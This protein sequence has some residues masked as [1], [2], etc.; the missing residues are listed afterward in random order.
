VPRSLRVR[1]DARRGEGARGRHL[2]QGGV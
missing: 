2:P 1:P